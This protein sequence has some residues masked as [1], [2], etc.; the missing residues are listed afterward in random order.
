MKLI[1]GLGNPTKEYENTKHNIGFIFIDNFCNKENISLTKEKFN[2]IY[3]EKTI[4]NEKILFIKPLSYMNLSGTVVKKY[5]DYYKIKIEDILV[6]QDDLDMNF[7]K[8]KLKNNGSSGGHNGIRNII[9]NINN[10]NFVR[11]KIGISKP[12]NNQ[13]IDYVLSKFT[14]EEINILNNKKEIVNNIIY[15]F[16]KGIPFSDIQSRYNGVNNENI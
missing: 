1:V 12:S 9:D 15:D 16:I 8:I 14:K 4:N 7:G 11:L 3:G 10:P 13:I 6:I 5:I 2:A